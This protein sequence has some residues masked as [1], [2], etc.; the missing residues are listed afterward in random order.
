MNYN[1][2]LARIAIDKEQISKFEL[3]NGFHPREKRFFTE[4]EENLFFS[5]IKYIKREDLIKN[6]NGYDYLKVAK[7]YLN[8]FPDIA[9]FENEF[10]F[11]NTHW[12][13][14]LD[15]IEVL[16]LGY[17]FRPSDFD[18]RKKIEPEIQNFAHS[19]MHNQDFNDSLTGKINWNKWYSLSSHYGN[20]I[21]QKFGLTKEIKNKVSLNKF[22]CGF[23]SN[24][25]THNKVNLRELL[26]SRQFEELVG[27]IYEN[28]GW[29]IELTKKTRDGGKDAIA[30]KNE[31]G[32]TIVAYI[33]AK[34]PPKNKIDTSKVREFYAVFRDETDRGFF[35]TTSE[36][37]EDA[38]KWVKQKK[39]IAP[40][41]FELIDKKGVLNKLV[42]ISK[43]SNLN[44]LSKWTKLNYK[45]NV[46]FVFKN[47]L[48]DAKQNQSI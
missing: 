35:V 19:F 2:I 27:M 26:S 34:N 33:E 4:Q 28:E 44:Y 8:H 36:F 5:A 6:D 48:W 23:I 3:L 37:T 38:R 15:K 14:L 20:S 17:I 40:V 21:E 29:K 22:P 9:K 43:N 18:E 47:I 10:E 25:L 39:L 32:E 24:Y 31:N 13:K 42:K 11:Y 1:D 46:S 45:N 30:T 41:V 12:D 7:E 16:Q